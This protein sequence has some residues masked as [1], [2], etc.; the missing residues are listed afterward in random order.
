MRQLAV[1]SKL[2]GVSTNLETSEVTLNNPSIVKLSLSREEIS[3]MTRVNQDLVIKLQS[4]ETITVKNFYVTNS[5]GTSQLVLEEG[6]GTLWWVENPGT[7][8]HSEQITSINDLLTASGGYHEGGAIWPWGLGGVVAAGGIAAIASYGGG[9]GGHH[10]SGD[11][12]NGGGSTGTDPGGSNPGGANPP[13]APT[14]LAV[15]GDGKTV[16]GHAEA[17]STITIKDPNGN[18]IGTGTAGRDGNFTITLASQQLE[19]QHLSVT[20][21][22]H[23]GTSP[24]ASVTAPNIPLPGDPT[25]DS[26]TD[27]VAPIT[28][29]LGQGQSTN[30]NHP[31]LQGKGEVGTTLHIYDNGTEIGSVAVNSNGTW[32]F[33]PLAPLSEGSHSFTVV[34][35]NIRGESGTSAAATIIVDT[36][37]PDAPVIGQLVNDEGNVTLTIANNGITNDSQPVLSGTGEAGD[38]ITVFDHGQSIGTVTVASNGQ[39]QFTPTPPLNDGSHSLTVQ[40]TDG[41]GN[42]SAIATGP[43]FTV[44]TLPPPAAVISTVSLDGTTVTG[45]AEARATITITGSNNQSLGTAIVDDQG[46]FT[47]TLVPA[48]TNGG[49]LE[50]H[51]QD[52]AGNLGPVT[53]FAAS[54][55]GFPTVPVI[56]SVVDDVAP[57]IGALT[58]GE[59]TNDNR[60]ELSGTAEI[61]AQISIFDNGLFIGATQAD[62]NG[63]WSFTPLLPLIDGEHSFTLMATNSNGTSGMSPAFH[64]DVDTQAPT[65]PSSLAVSD[66]GTTVTGI[67][68]AGSTVTVSDSSGNPLGTGTAGSDETFTVTITPAQIN[69][70]NLNVTATDAADNTGQ[71][72]SIQAP[73][74]TPPAA[75]SGL[76]I[77][78]NGT[79][80]TGSAE[81]GSTVTITDGQG[82]NLGTTQADSSGHFSANLTPAQDNGEVLFATATDNASNSS[83]NTSITAPD[84]TPPSAPSDVEI[85]DEGTIVTGKAEAGSTVVVT[86][87]TGQQ[88]GNTTADGSGNFS[89]IITPPQIDG[90][91]LEVTA[92]DKANNTSPQTSVTAP[93]LTPPDAPVIGAV[94]DDQPLFTGSLSS[95]QTTNDNKPEITGTTEANSTVKIYDNGMLIGQVT[96]DNQGQWDFTPANA[97]GEGGHLITVTATDAGGNV[98]PSTSFNLVVDTVAPQTP[99]IT[100]I[101][102]D[103][104]P[105]MG[106]IANGGYTND[107]TPT[108]SGIGEPGT[109]ITLY[110]GT[111]VVTTLVVGPTGSW[112]YAITTPL[113]ENTHTFTVTATDI[114]GNSAT[115]AAYSITFDTVAPAAPVILNVADNTGIIQGTIQSGGIT[116]ETHP[117]LNGTATAGTTV[118]FYDNGNPIGNVVADTN[119]VWTFTPG[120]SL[121]NGSHTLTAIA[122]D[123]A[124]NPS[125][126][127]TFTLTVDTI[128]PAA[129]QL[130]S[131]SGDV[132]GV[133]E[134]LSS[135]SYTQSTSPELSGKSETNATITLSDNGVIIGTTTADGNGNWN[136]TPTLGQG[137]HTLTATATDTAGNTG[138]SSAGFTLTVDSIAPAT[139]AAPTVTDD[140]A[141]I[142]G[143]VA[144]GGQT[145][146]TTPTFSGQGNAGDTITLYN[147]GITVI[148]TT[149]VGADGHWSFTPATPLSETNY[150][151]TVT[152]TDAA[153]NVSQPSAASTFTVDTTPPAVPEITFADDDV[154]AI[155]GEIFTNGITDDTQPVLHG[156]GD[157]GSTITVYNGSTVMGQATVDTNGDWSLTPTSP[158]GNGTVNLTAVATDAAGNTTGASANFTLTVNATPLTLPVVTAI[159]DNVDPVQGNLVSGSAT[160]DQTPTF[161]GTG[162][163]G[164]TVYLYDGANTTPIGSA[165][166]SSDGTWTITPSDDLSD[167]PHQF[168]LTATDTA[169]N[170]IGPS[171][172]VT[173][174]VD[175]LPPPAPVVSTP[176]STGT[177]ITGTAE[178][179][180]TVI[181]KDRTTGTVLGEGQTDG[182]GHFT[183][184]ISPAQTTGESLSATA[185]DPAGNLS[186]ETDFIAATS[187]IPHP[188]VITT[189][190]DDVTPVL[191]NVANNGST[192]DTLPSLNGTATANATV[193]IYV[194]GNLTDSVSADSSGNWSYQLSSALINGQHTFSVTQNVAGTDSGHSPNYTIIV[195]TVAPGTPVLTGVVDDIAPVTGSIS[196]GQT[197]NDARPTF[198]GTGEAGS[199]VSIYDNGTQIGTA[200]VGSNGTWTFTPGGDLSNS[201]HN[202]TL[203]AT[204]AAGNQSSFSF[205]FSF[206]VDTQLPALPV[207]L[208]VT[209][210]VGGTITLTSGQ[211]TNYN[212]PAL[213]GTAEAGATVIIYDNGAKI[214]SVVAD[215]DGSWSFTPGTALA[216]GSHNLIL[217]AT[218]AAGNVSGAT[219]VFNIIVD[220]L[221]P[222]VPTITSV[223]DDQGG[224]TVLVNGQ[225]TNDAQP[226]VSGHSE[227]NATIALYDGTALVGTTT[228]DAAG[229]WSLTPDTPLGQGNHNLNVTATDAAGN[230]SNASPGF[231]LVVDTIAPTIPVITSVTDSTAPGTG[232]LVSGQATNETRPALSGT[233]EAGS[234]ITVYSDGNVIGTTTVGAGGTW[235]LT[236]SASLLNGSHL[237]TV[238]ASD[239]AGNVSATSAPFTIL[240]DTAPPATPVVLTVADDVGS[241]IG[242]LLNGQVTDDSR[243]AL[244]GTSE[245]NATINVYDNGI[246]IGST[247][248]DAAGTWS[249]TPS[250]ELGN[251]SHALTVTASDAAGNVSGA[252]SAFNIIVDTVAPIAPVIIQ[253]LDDVAPV[254]GTLV[255]SQATNDNLPTFS[256]TAEAG[257]TV[258]I[259]D[260]GTLSGTVTAAANGSWSFTPAT[261]LSD[262]N[263]TITATATD[264][265]GNLS[266]IS[267]NFVLTVD[268]AAPVTPQLQ[269][270][271]DDVAGGVFG[272]LANGQVTNDARPTLNG[273]AEAGSTVKIYDGGTLIGTTVATNGSWTFTP[274]TS[275]TTGS[276]TF[277]ITAT[278]SAGNVSAV[279]SGFTVV[280]DITAPV[281]PIITSVVDDIAPVTGTVASNGATNDTMP[282]LNGT[283]EAGATVNIYDNGILLA[284]VT[285]NSSGIWQ[286]TPTTALGQGTHAFSVTAT[287]VAGNT[288][289]SSSTTTI[290]VDTTPPPAPVVLTVNAT[291]TTVTGTAEA[292]STV[293]IT[294]NTGTVLGSAVANG[295]GAFTVALSPAQTSGQS[296]LAWAQDAAGNV[297]PQF[298]FTAPDTRLPDAPT[299]T[300]VVDDL[301]PHTGALVNAQ[302]TNDAQ[303]TLNGTA[304]AGATVNIYNNGALLGSVQAGADGS[305]SYTS[306]SSLSD[307]T[308]AFTAT[309]TNDN[310]TGSASGAI[311]VLVDT[312]PPAI[313]TAVVSADGSTISGMAEANSTVTI[314]LPGG[315]ILTTTANAQGGYT[316]TFPTRQ[317]DGEALSVTATDLAGNTSQPI[318]LTAPTLPLSATDNVLDLALT[319]PATI[320]TQHYSDYGSMLVGALGNVAT[321]LGSNT[322]QVEFSIAN[323]GTGEVNID[324]T[325][326]GVVLSLLMSL[327]IAI[328]KY[329]STTGTWSTIIDST[330]PQFANLLTLGTS[331]VTLHINALA[332]GDYRVLTYNTSLLATGSLTNIDVSVVQTSNATVTGDT[333]HPGNV[334]TDVDPVH[335]VDTAP[336][337]TLVTAITNAQGQTVAVGPSGA[338]IQGLYGTLH[339]NPN[340]SY[341]YTLTNTSASVLGHTDSFTYTLTD[342]GVNNSA[343]LVLTLGNGAPASTVTAADNAVSLVYNTDVE[344]VTHTNS[345]QTGTS[346]LSVGVGN[347]VNLNLLAGMTN[348]ILFDVAE[349]TTRTMTL[350][351][352][353][354][355]IA[356][357]STFDLY[358]YKF[359]PITQ[360]YE[361]Y[362]TVDNWLSAPLLGGQSG[363]LT[364]TLP[365]GDY[366]FMLHNASG[367]AVPTSYTL[368]ITNDH[369]YSV[370]SLSAVTTGNVMQNDIAPSGTLLTEVNGVAIA[371]TGTTTISGQYGTLTIDTQGNYTYTL[372]SGVGADSTSTPDSFVYTIKAP[373]GDSGTASLNISPT[374]HA[375]SAVNDTSAVMSINTAQQTLT[376]SNT[377]VGTAT[378]SNPL[379]GTGSGSGNGTFVVDANTILHAPVLHF[380]IISGLS[381]ASLS[382]TWS[383]Y[384]GSTFIQSGTFSGT[385]TTI[386]LSALDLT[387]GTYTLNYSGSTT[388]LGSLGSYTVTPSVTGTTVDLDT[389]LS[390]SGSTVHGNIY[391]GT[392]AA[393]ATDQLSTV[394]TQLS[395][396]GFNG[397]TTTLDPL[398]AANSATIQGHYGTLTINLD[399]SYTYAL[400]TGVNIAAI[401]SPETFNY[402]LNDQNGHTA[403]ATLTINMNPQIASTAQNDVITGSSYGDTL[404]YHLLNTNSATGGNGSDTWTNFSLTQNDKIDLHELLTGWN[405]QASTL[406]NFVQVTTSGANTVISIDRDGTGSTYQYTTLVTLDNTH[407]TLQE[408]LQQN[409]LITG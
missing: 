106:N 131:A 6:N 352:S 167:G 24:A 143:S 288:G 386:N 117:V 7:S 253:A 116:D 215:G 10:N 400:N 295:N 179:G 334:I 96:A 156:R 150:S 399:G 285:S 234:T 34:A 359:N 16:T 404:I 147:N 296:L 269:S 319:S 225:L 93:D 1:I 155:R 342:N 95:G 193:S 49:Q 124:G 271:V 321:V 182:I 265:A 218:D 48:Q 14:A 259:Y 149:T 133:N 145:N 316:L 209:D 196:A 89:V 303:P 105:I 248:A 123:A 383:L 394:H 120:L 86:T 40:Q 75:P 173:L 241:V 405:H 119:G 304:L 341:T 366:L 354:G 189:V 408:L 168:T 375:L 378:W 92:T 15:S 157:A 185:Q 324:A 374:A 101:A 181:I 333:S 140:F 393:G 208:T 44:D 199:T 323:G 347:V 57:G 67:A 365:G 350:Q 135:G 287:D 284:S 146:D 55:S 246:L 33:T 360:Q 358:I 71:P 26:I 88:L 389:Y 125:T 76:Q 272:N 188:P 361:Q 36:T 318:G 407:T 233:G 139:P 232:V 82:N 56:T 260:N 388:G 25:I 236:P 72:G 51:I 300:S 87:E 301:A 45:T 13:A 70:E 166:V 126:A 170:N 162:A 172:P 293:T 344:A 273:S 223:V 322:A 90:E 299:I 314:S 406:G 382:G 111:S 184:L 245:A 169:G 367:I 309:A 381:L 258:K 266:A 356:L 39:W 317:I 110:D 130:L 302:V 175:T 392:D 313:P 118:T 53:D 100:L 277:T 91:T 264:A 212:Q 357:A 214:G 63:D 164:S 207:L 42:V 282:T 35:T 19:G 331:G 32:S 37:A 257:S 307:G 83:P 77:D 21:S 249:F 210:D 80:V 281:A 228:A 243:P 328:Q 151:I 364:V 28:G 219:G 362:K 109:T 380:G 332:S 335:G 338:D 345:T 52:T 81:A 107:T 384:Q 127:A 237:L 3:Q 327:E 330:M 5:Q 398:G 401:T 197:T 174:T 275:L 227:A 274:A 144:N 160:N 402:A 69:H 242:N 390:Q 198:S 154:G 280:V 240:V 41:A 31:T 98:S 94:I 326:T 38:T 108:L 65:Q 112:S 11:T 78:T 27:D 73:D 230:A 251:G 262:G 203:L 247:Q 84:H 348:P 337:G 238:S 308:H 315:V 138:A 64:L 340:G 178:A 132:G 137:S 104:L 68:E 349:G 278:D 353:V 79:V 256:G 136:F 12:G 187:S 85:N 47:I 43:T 217:T 61:G 368:N 66:D 263:H 370:D 177:L 343:H 294:S 396:T 255:S 286:Y 369:T 351:S 298:P 171:A 385:N 276:H 29:T 30:D 231:A 191:G 220:T 329:D 229:N 250:T 320:T 297:G 305:W 180:S 74:H 4:G 373:N 102:D 114:A 379:V 113:S 224:T 22:D 376:Y 46:H 377:S 2:T 290:T 17:G 291:G 129:P 306:G 103:Q 141:P 158:L 371:S 59:A 134:T 58:N 165:T 159:T 115:S 163:I 311:S 211:S 346:V 336:A 252:T 62:S 97:L 325:A 391:D 201:T 186:P 205:G 216:D 190:V 128:A 283:V 409:H 206:T 279:T 121:S 310:G 202:I 395:I 372:R 239:A 268:T 183:V 254:T 18:I 270:V 194:D 363:Q 142:T 153:G 312:T 235:S 99:A 20:A 403:S 122:T 355:G 192:N 397:T 222:A 387:A 244:T 213:A 292:G 339:I 200:S 221:A 261:A 152:E 50:A 267:G 289:A 148:G 54:S 226:A 204:D 60:P 161:T 195:D 9:G 23:A 176:D 8:L